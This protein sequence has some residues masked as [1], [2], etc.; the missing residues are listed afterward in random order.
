MSYSAETTR[1]ERPG[2]PGERNIWI[3]SSSTANSAT[4]AWGYYLSRDL[5]RQALQQANSQLKVLCIINPV[6][7]GDS[8]IL[9]CWHCRWLSPPWV[10]WPLSSFSVPS[11]SLHPQKGLLVLLTFASLFRDADLH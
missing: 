9:W 4:L 11:I 3:R 10:S 6:L 7:L 5:A 1:T 8:R 2:N